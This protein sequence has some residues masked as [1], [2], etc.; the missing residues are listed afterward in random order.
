METGDCFTKAISKSKS[1]GKRYY[2]NT[3]TG[4]S[5]WGVPIYDKS[6]E[7]KVEE[8]VSGW[9]IVRS[10]NVDSRRVY[11]SNP[12]EGIS[13]WNPPPKIE[14]VADEPLSDG[15]EKRLSKCKNVYYFNK[16][17]NRS[18]WEIPKA[19]S[20]PKPIAEPIPETIAKPI[21]KPIVK[22]RPEPIP[23]NRKP[24]PASARIPAVELPTNRKPRP[25]SARI[26]AVELPTNRKPRALKWTAN[27][28]YLDS[29]L[30]AFFA[31]PKKFI[32]EMLTMTLEDKVDRI[33]LKDCIG[34]L[35]T[36]LEHRKKIQDELKKIYESITRTGDRV[37]DCTELRKALTNCPNKEKYHG[38]DVGD[39]GEFINYLTSLFPIDKNIINVTTYLTNVRG[40]DLDQLLKYHPET[41]KKERYEDISL[42]HVIHPQD[43]QLNAGLKFKLSDLL[44]DEVENLLQPGDEYNEDGVSYR[45]QITIR[46]LISS[47]YLIINLKR[48]IQR[49]APM[50]T[51]IFV[52][53]SDI[54]INEQVFTLTGVVMHTGG[55]HYVAIAKYNE[56]WWYYD[57]NPNRPPILIEFETFDNFVSIF[58][59]YDDYDHDYKMINPLTHGTQ[60]YYTPIDVK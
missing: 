32:H 15:W 14:H 54:T 17:E 5:R 44:N 57:D 2:V 39:S 60:F 23:T 51:D 43:Q 8:K 41:V 53:D 31:G 50:I 20:I 37:E 40:I 56:K 3:E 9:E 13:Q 38:G 30:F 16:K 4:L 46:T 27:S 35:K 25:A 21:V 18:Q 1:K 49:D 45:R 34:D 47:P 22:P 10:V 28:C 12:S 29:A 42:V 36:N 11:F 6:T 19:I 26:P 7:L 55:C 58:E 59:Y 52:P 33:V 24:R 48:L